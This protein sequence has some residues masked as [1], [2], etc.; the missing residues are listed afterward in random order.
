M[1]GRRKILNKHQ[2]YSSADSSTNPSSLHTDISGIDNILYVVDID[3]SVDGSL[4]VEQCGDDKIIPSSEFKSLNFGENIVLNSAND[5]E[6][7]LSIKN[8]GFKWMRLSF[9]NNGGSG[10]INAWISGNSVGA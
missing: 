8:Q 2:V 6:Y 3:S 5:T 4:V 9:N 1:S 10:N 7:T